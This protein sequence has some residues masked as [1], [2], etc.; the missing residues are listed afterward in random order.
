MKNYIFFFFKY[1]FPA[2]VHLYNKK[3]ETT[4]NSETL[5]GPTV[6]LLTP[7]QAT[8][9]DIYTIIKSYLVASDVSCICIYENDD[10]AEQI[11]KLKTSMPLNL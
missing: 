8:K 6:L 7:H 9:D 10:K 1:L 3:K 2:I 5:H 4:E 11:E